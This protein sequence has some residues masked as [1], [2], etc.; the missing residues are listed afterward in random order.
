MIR[1]FFVAV[2]E[3]IRGWALRLV[4]RVLRW[5]GGLLLRWGLAIEEAAD[6]M[7]GAT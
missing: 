7:K 2:W 3:R 6:A 5:V 4:A 1:A